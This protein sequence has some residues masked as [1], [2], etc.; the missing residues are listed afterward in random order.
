MPRLIRAGFHV[1]KTSLI[2]KRAR[3]FLTLAAERL[4]DKGL[5]WQI[6]SMGIPGGKP[7]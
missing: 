3:E 1:V 2:G 7:G 5:S 4:G 6:A